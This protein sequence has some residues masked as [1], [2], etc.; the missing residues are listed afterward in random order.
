MIGNQEKGFIS[1]P[2][3]RVGGLLLCSSTDLAHT[4]ILALYA[5]MK[6]VALGGSRVPIK[7]RD[8]LASWAPALCQPSAKHWELEMKTFAPLPSR[9]MK[10]SEHEHQLEAEEVQVRIL[11][12]ALLAS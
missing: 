5:Q 2:S 12:L 9:S 1:L 4:L 11:T 3:D 8:S 7:F 10:S 6:L